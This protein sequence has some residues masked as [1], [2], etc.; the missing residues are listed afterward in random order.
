MDEVAKQFDEQLTKTIDMRAGYKS[1]VDSL[2][3]N[4][5]AAA[6]LGMSQRKLDAKAAR[7][8]EGELTAL[9][10][11]SVEM[12]LTQAKEGVAKLMEKETGVTCPP[13]LVPDV[14][15]TPV[16]GIYEQKALAGIK[17]AFA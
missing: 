4:I 14:A 7:K 17:A 9:V 16:I 11:A 8:A 2:R 3:A 5:R 13:S 15:V 1:A 12:V 10:D 6:E